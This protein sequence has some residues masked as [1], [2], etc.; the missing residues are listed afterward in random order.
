MKFF[1]L[2]VAPRKLFVLIALVAIGLL[3]HHLVEHFSSTVEEQHE[4]QVCTA[5]HHTLPVHPVKAI[6][7]S[8][9]SPPSE[10]KALSCPL[11][12]SNVA[13]TEIRGRSP[14]FTA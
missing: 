3:Q 13:Y 9:G 8:L 11:V 14:P 12:T 4:C 10:P 1:T 7:P 6:S 5:Y 2:S